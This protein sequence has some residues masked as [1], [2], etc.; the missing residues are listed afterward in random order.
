MRQS[1]QRGFL[2]EEE[3]N[4]RVIKEIERKMVGRREEMEKTKDDAT[5][6][7]EELGVDF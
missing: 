6:E 7:G 2:E 3:D 1:Y 5:M 4:L